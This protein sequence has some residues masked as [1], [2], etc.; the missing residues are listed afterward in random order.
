[1]KERPKL[2][3]DSLS[4]EFIPELPAG[5]SQDSLATGVGQKDL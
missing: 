2:T 4:L 1:M 5:P 3:A